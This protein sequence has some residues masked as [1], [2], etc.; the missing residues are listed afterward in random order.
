M[1]F[2][3]NASYLLGLRV[4]TVG[5]GMVASVVV[6]RFLG[7]E[8]KG[9]LHLVFLLPRLIV[10]FGGLGIRSSAVYFGGRGADHR[11][12]VRTVFGVGV[13]LAGV[14]VAAGLLLRG[15]IHATLLQGM[16]S[17]W[18][19]L[20]LALIP[21]YM[22]SSCGE[23]LLQ[24]LH[25]FG[26]MTAIQVSSQLLKVVLLVI[27]VAW[28]GGGLAAGMLSYS[29]VAL[30]PAVLNLVAVSRH[31]GGGGRGVSS[32]EVLG[33]GLRTHL[34]TVAQLSNVRIDVF[35]M[36]PLVGT[37]AVGI[38]SVAAMLADLVLYVPGA[39]S[40]VLFPRVAGSDPRR[41]AEETAFLARQ[42]IVLA[43]VPAVLLG[44]AA[45]WVVVLFFGVE[46][47]GAIRALWILIPGV[48]ALSFG[49]IL[50]QYLAG[51]GRPGLNSIASVISLA[52]NIPLLLVL[53]PRFGIYGAAAASTLAYMLRTGIVTVFYL[54]R[55][56]LPA[57]AI[58][59]PRPGDFAT[60][61]RLA[62]AV[63]RRGPGR[64]GPPVPP[65]DP[66]F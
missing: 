56:G 49:L 47:E 24:G 19:L 37:A 1:G 46:F 13:V 9:I 29:L 40:Q 33:Y 5:A 11:R 59:V 58:L 35:I 43:G 64:G 2:Q 34:G 31:A 39:V 16:E 41:A 3:R 25:R 26:T 44:I 57:S 42:T 38:Y 6:A 15:P 66:T 7:A 10:G 4:V 20:S 17:K 51:T 21:V 65:V 50:N 18:V 54:R 30:L 52:L 53:V 12:L 45:Q 48:I 60:Y 55:S 23:G 27:L 22:F 28:V 8:G 62:D 63:L 32:R 14:Y 61:R 36:N